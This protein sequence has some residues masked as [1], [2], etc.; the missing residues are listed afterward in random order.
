MSL[1]FVL[2]VIGLAVVLGAHDRDNIFSTFGV[3]NTRDLATAIEKYIPFQVNVTAK[4]NGTVSHTANTTVTPWVPACTSSVLFGSFGKYCLEDSLNAGTFAANLSHWNNFRGTLYFLAFVIT[5]LFMCVVYAV[6]RQKHPQG[7]L[8][9]T[10]GV[11][12]YNNA[13]ILLFDTPLYEVFRCAWFVTG[14]V[15]FFWVANAMTS[16]WTFYRF[17]KNNTEGKLH[18]FWIAYHNKFVASVVCVTIYLSW[19]LLL[20]GAEIAVWIAFVIPWLGIRCMLKPGLEHVRPD[21]PL[22]E[23]P[24]WVRIDMFFTEA[25]QIRRLGFS[26]R[27]WE[28]V[29]G[30]KDAFCP[31]MD[32]CQMGAMAPQQ[33]WQQPPHQTAV[34]MSQRPSAQAPRLG[35]MGEDPRAHH[36]A[37][38]AA[39]PPGGLV[40]QDTINVRSTQG[41]EEVTEK[42]KKKKHHSKEK[43]GSSTK[44]RKER[45]SKEKKEKKS[46]KDKGD[47]SD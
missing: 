20:L 3:E 4:C 36:P 2:S 47:D 25:Q 26:N 41:E 28:M 32:C 38:P 16:Y 42:K 15:I 9:N 18:D 17:Y 6:H 39:V 29:T 8:M 10:S 23:M 33:P 31:S 1:F 24:G 40:A 7:G 37:A 43:E 5:L 45:K 11:G 44:E 19:P 35:H 14:T 12:Q 13:P 21:V 34:Q 30:S 46:K 27:L 22:S